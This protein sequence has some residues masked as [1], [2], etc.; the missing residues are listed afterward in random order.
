MRY[1]RDQRGETAALL[2]L[3]SGERKSAHGAAMEGAEE[4]DHVLPAGV[5]PRDFSA[6]SIASAPELP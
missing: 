4:G 1:A 5:I 6:H 2:R 3:G